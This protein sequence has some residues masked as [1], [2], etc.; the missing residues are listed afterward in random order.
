MT[1]EFRL[2]PSPLPRFNGS[3]IVKRKADGEVLGEFFE[4]DSVRQFN[5]ATCEA[6]PIGVHLASLNKRIKDNANN[7]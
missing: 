3:W 7:I 4:P 2:E 1:D 5:G 6:I